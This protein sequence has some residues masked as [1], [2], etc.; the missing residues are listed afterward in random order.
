MKH[1]DINTWKR[2][3]VFNF[4]KDFNFPRYQ[5]TVEIDIKKY[6]DY[7]KRHHLPIFFGI[8]HLVLSKMNEIDNFKYRILDEGVILHDTLHPSFTDKIKDGDTFKIV[9]GKYLDDIKSFCDLSKEISQKQ[10]DLF[11]DFREEQRSD[12]VYVSSFP[13]AKYTQ[14]S[15]ATMV[16]PYD[17]IPRIIWGKFEDINGKM[18]MPLTIEVHHALVDGYHVGLLIKNIEKTISEM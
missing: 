4:Y 13:W 17:A 12:L 8:M 16:E 15:N 3:E 7:L 1:I 5:V 11:I 10:G 6:Y 18:M 14:I 9:T 2:K